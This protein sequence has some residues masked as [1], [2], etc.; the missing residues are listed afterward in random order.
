MPVPESR[1]YAIFSEEPAA[2]TVG[3]AHIIPGLF[4]GADLALAR[5][6]ESGG[7]ETAAESGG[8]ET[9]VL[10]DKPVGSVLP[11]VRVGL[12]VL[13]FRLLAAVLLVSLSLGVDS[14][15]FRF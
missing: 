5:G 14:S 3:N 12:C 8:A 9:A 10:E 11:L 13:P 7:S 6:A 4:G 1:I 15:F 2:A